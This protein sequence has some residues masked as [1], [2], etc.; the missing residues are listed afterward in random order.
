MDLQHTH[1]RPRHKFFRG[2]KTAVASVEP[3]LNSKAIAN[4]NIEAS[5]ESAVYEANILL[6]YSFLRVSIVDN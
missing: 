1:R 4:I 3:I 5:A 6:P 2:S